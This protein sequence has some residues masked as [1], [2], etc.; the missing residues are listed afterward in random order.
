MIDK[1]TNPAL[2]ISFLSGLKLLLI[3]F[4]FD[5]FSTEQAEAI[6]NGIAALVLV[7]MGIIAKINESKAQAELAAANAKLE[8]LERYSKR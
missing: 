2:I 6:A 1:L 7:I 8:R 3:P 5:V 4:G